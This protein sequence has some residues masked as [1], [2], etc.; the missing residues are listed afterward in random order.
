MKKIHHDIEF[1]VLRKKLDRV[2]SIEEKIALLEQLV[3]LN[4]R[5]PRNLALR[6]KYRESIETLRLKK[7]AR[8]KVMASPY[9]AIHYKKQVALVGETSTG[10][11]TLLNRLT[12]AQTPV[13]ELPFTTYRPEVQTMNYKDVAIQVIEVP[14]LYSGDSDTAKYRFIR[15]SDVLCIC[16]K[17]EEDFDLTAKQLQNYYIKLTSVPTPSGE[18]RQYRLNDEIVGKP[19][20]IASRDK[21]IKGGNL[22]V[23]DI[24][25]IEAISVQIYSLFNIKRIYSLRNGEVQEK[26]LVFSAD[27]EVTVFDFIKELDKRMLS[28]FKRAKITHNDTAIHGVQIVGLDYKLSDGDVVEIL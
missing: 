1:M 19:T 8:K 23:I 16:A 24:N 4:P 12:G 20:F 5:N 15:N 17:T 10:K 7:G 9:D 3:S 22:A 27:Q 14:A 18:K 6:R 28:D 21:N 11:S 13:Q 25:D 26:P 2:D